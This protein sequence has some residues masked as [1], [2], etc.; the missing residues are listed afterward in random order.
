MADAGC[1]G[2]ATIVG[3]PDLAVV[4]ATAGRCNRG[5]AQNMPM[6]LPHAGVIGPPAL[7][8]QPADRRSAASAVAVSRCIYW[9]FI[10][11][12]AMFQGAR[13]EWRPTGILSV[14]NGKVGDPG[15]SPAGN[16]GFLLVRYQCDTSAI[17]AVGCIFWCDWRPAGALQRR[18]AG[19]E[20]CK[21]KGPDIAVRPFGDAPF[22]GPIRTCSSGR[23]WPARLR[24]WSC[25]HRSRWAPES[26]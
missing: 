25:R 13:W 20:V 2:A 16:R 10:A 15:G 14:Q 3:V 22:G 17:P 9:F 24:C 19:A 11:D 26:R 6:F 23:R 1:M 7:S 12:S 5:V 8:G 21:R 18:N 4:V